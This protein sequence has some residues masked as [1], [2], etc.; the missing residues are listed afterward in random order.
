M[1]RFNIVVTKLIMV[2][3]MQ[4]H[5]SLLL[6]ILMHLD[7]NYLEQYQVLLVIKSCWCFILVVTLSEMLQ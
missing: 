4:F 1:A 3:I 6:C 5:F 7:F 2:L